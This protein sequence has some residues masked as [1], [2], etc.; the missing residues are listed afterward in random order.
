MAEQARNLDETH[1]S[2]IRDPRDSLPPLPIRAAGRATTWIVARFPAL[3]PLVRWPTRKFFDRAA[4]GWDKRISPIPGHLTAL[5]AGLDRLNRPPERTLDVGTGTGVAALLLARRFPR[6]HVVG[7]DISEPMI[8]LARAKLDG[9]LATRVEF[10]V[11]DAAVLPFDA[12]SFDLVAQVSVPVFFDE[13]ARVLQ[14]GG[15][16][17]I[18]NS[19]GQATPTYLPGELLEKGFARRGLESIAAGRAGAGTY[20]VAVKREAGPAQQAV[21]LTTKGRG[22]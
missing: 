12:S 2:D 15:H 20:L 13:I 21:D 9:E 18:V 22:S 8:R 19:I 7:I 14:P 10:A 16:A 5:E 3:W 1:A 17:V 11:A 6:A 4:R